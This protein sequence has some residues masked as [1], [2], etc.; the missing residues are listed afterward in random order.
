MKNQV[1]EKSV[2]QILEYWHIL[3]YYKGWIL[4]ATLM[5]TLAATVIIALLPD[6]YRATTTILVDPQKIPERYVV[7]TVNS[8]PA[9]RLN[10]LSQEVLSFTRLERII[11]EFGLYP[12]MRGSYPIEQ[13]VERMRKA[14][15]IEVKEGSGEALSAF[16]I[17]Y[18][19]SDPLKAAEV[20][21]RL[22]ATFIEW[23]EQSR[24]QQAVGTTAFLDSHLQRANKALEHQERSLRQFRMQHLGEMPD[25]LQANL[26]TVAGLRMELQASSDALDHL[27]QERLLLLSS[28]A[29]AVGSGVTPGPLDERESLEMEKDQV[30]KKLDA[31]RARYSPAYPDVIALEHRLQHINER[32]AKL[33]PP[34]LK[35]APPKTSSVAVRLEIIKREESKLKNQR[36]AIQSQI[37]AYQAKI[38]AEPLREEQIADLSRN[39]ETSKKLYDSLLEKT[40]SAEMA[41][42]LEKKQKAERFT[43]LD[44]ARAPEKPFKPNRL[45]LMLAA[46]FASLLASCG[47]FMGREKL[48]TAVKAETE[49]RDMLPKTVS[50]LATVPRVETPRERRRRVG[51]ALIAAGVAVLA[52]L[53]VAGFL[54]KVHPIL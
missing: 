25:Q 11:D 27:E 13:I 43:I 40:Y 4:F 49:L 9:D 51:I 22:A 36:A 6:T 7:P 10:T 30:Q 44:P 47:F 39:Y 31:M 29:G 28:P 18:E 20:A 26:Q 14:I 3:L 37:A 5:L 8:N 12:E 54:W 48:N 45:L 53:L 19:A 33:P 21:N 50:F 34:S 38:D 32:L 23:N 35:K 2:A 42:D 16:T 41:T 52:C 1:Q 46:G 24:E 17:S 15:Q